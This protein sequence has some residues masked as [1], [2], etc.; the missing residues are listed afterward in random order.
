MSM[1]IPIICNDGVGDTS[2]LILKYTAG[3][4]IP[5]D[6]I[7]T[8]DLADFSFDR[9][10]SMVGAESYFGL[11]NGVNTYSNIYKKIIN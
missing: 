8:Y 1:G 7:K 4:V 11:Q 9:S 3:A 5:S 2:D 10:Q 6:Q